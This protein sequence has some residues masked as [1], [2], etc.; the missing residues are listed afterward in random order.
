MAALRLLLPACGLRCGCFLLI[1]QISHKG[2]LAHDFGDKLDIIQI[3]Y[4]FVRGAVTIGL[5]LL[6]RFHDDLF[7]LRRNSRHLRR[8]RRHRL[9]DVHQRDGN[10]IVPVKRHLTGQHLVENNAQR[11]DVRAFVH[12]SAARLLR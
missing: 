6:G 9:I 1:V 12:I 11:I 10:R 2:F 7:Q 5:I 8:H 3:F 4:H